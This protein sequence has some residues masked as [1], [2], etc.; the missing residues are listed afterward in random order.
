MVSIEKSPV[1][2][3]CVGDFNQ[4]DVVDIAGEGY[5]VAWFNGAETVTVYPAGDL[6]PDS[7]GANHRQVSSR[8]PCELV[9]EPCL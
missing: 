2:A 6:L 5:R 7:D 4:G 8:T 3:S 9:L 1:L